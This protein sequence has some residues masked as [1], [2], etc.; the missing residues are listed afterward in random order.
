M[1]TAP[2]VSE[3]DDPAYAVFMGLVL[4]RSGGEEPW[5]RAGYEHVF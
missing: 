2:V 4:E 3:N 1:R 5:P